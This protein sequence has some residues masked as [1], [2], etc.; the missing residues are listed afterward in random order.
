MRQKN[1]SNVSPEEKAAIVREFL[2]WQ[3]TQPRAR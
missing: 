1:I 3:K 2:E